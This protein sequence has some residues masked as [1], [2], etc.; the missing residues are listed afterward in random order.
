[1]AASGH[2]F[3]ALKPGKITPGRLVGRPLSPA[4]VRAMPERSV[5]I[6]RPKNRFIRIKAGQHRVL[7]DRQGNGEA[8]KKAFKG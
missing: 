1:M 7:N 6:E 5:V 3:G 2:P 4:P 8:A